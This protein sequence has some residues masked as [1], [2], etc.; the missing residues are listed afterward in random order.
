MTTINNLPFIGTV[1][2]GDQL[3]LFV[4]A[5]GAT[6]KTSIDTLTS[7][8]QANLSVFI[9]N[10]DIFTKANVIA[11]S[12]DT[13][14]PAFVA[15]GYAVV[16]DCS[17]MLWVKMAVAPT[18]PQAWQLQTLDGAWWQLSVGTTIDPRWFGASSASL[19]N[20]AAFNTAI[21]FAAALNGGQILVPA[22][23]FTFTGTLVVSTANISIVGEN[24]FGSV[25]NFANRALDCLTVQGP[26][27]ALLIGGFTLANL[28]INGSSKS[29]G[30]ALLLAFGYRAVIENLHVTNSYTG[31][32]IFACN[33]VYMSNVTFQGIPG[34]SGT[35]FFALGPTAQKPTACYGIFWHGGADNN[36]ICLQLTT[37]NVTVSAIYSGADGFV[38][39]GNAA[40]WNGDQVTALN[41]RYGLWVKNST[42]SASYIPE[43]MVMH[44]FNTDGMTAA[45]LRIDTGS[46]FSFT[47]S[48]IGNTS[49]SGGQGNADT[50]GLIINPDTGFGYTRE[51]YFTNCRIGLSKQGAAYVAALDVKFT[52]CTFA[53]GATQPDNTY[54]G[55]RIAAPSNGVIVD[56]CTFYL[57]GAP[58]NFKYAV[59]VD[60]GTSRV[61]LMGNDINTVGGLGINWQNTD[62]NSRNFL[63]SGIHSSVDNNHLTIPAGDTVTGNYTIAAAHLVGGI[64][65][66][67]GTPGAGFTATI[68]T[69][70]N[71]VAALNAP[72]IGHTFEVRIGNTTGQIMTLAAGTG[73]AIAGSTT[74]AANSGRT[75]SFR[76]NNTVTGSQSV[77]VYG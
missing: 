19:D 76:V 65:Y 59:Q 1:S 45:G 73:V 48:F 37:Y 6:F 10:S 68:D 67:S 26:S 47:G 75:F 36:T 28:S 27:V 30:R 62:A 11:N 51:L 23:T 57:Y 69:A 12:F 18:T 7:Y 20:T 3:P 33:D 9:A 38:W 53:S 43:F 13:S 8:L 24:R 63:V 22:Q 16:G 70:A 60:A 42:Q 64:Y 39:D 50:Q 55:L 15:L 35:N 2:S 72:A 52:N 61:L 29:G 66:P 5:E 34:G 46:A 56:G 77:S 71:I 31:F 4:G 17:P 44:N 32:E 21:A 74:I 49:G 40:T 14:V 54:P 25:L 41:C 58:N